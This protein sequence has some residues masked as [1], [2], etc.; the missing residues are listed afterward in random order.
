MKYTQLTEQDRRSMLE[1]LG[2]SVVGE[3]FAPISSAHRLDQPL[4]IPPGRS[5]PEVLADLT[6]LAGAN[7]ACDELVCFLG[8]GAYDHFI[9]TLVD[10]LAMKGEFLTAYTPYQAEASQGSLQAFYEFQTMVCQLLGMDV[11]NASLYEQASAVAEAVLMVTQASR[12]RRVLVCGA[13]HPDTSAVLATY[14]R[15]ADFQC[16]ALPLTDGVTDLDALTQAVDEQTAAVVVQ[17][18]NFFGCLEPADRIAQI[19]HQ[20]GAVVIGCTDP[21]ACGLIKRPGDWGADIAVAE[22]QAL[23]IPLSYGGPYVGLMACGEK[24]LRKMPG[25]VV[26]RGRD[27]KGSQSFCLALQTREQH[28]RRE[29][30]TSNICTNQGLMAL[31]VAVYLSAMG[32]Q[33][34]ATVAGHCLDKAHYA[35]GLIAG[36]DGYEL[37]F[38]QPF[39][40]EFTVKTQRN[41]SG[42]LSHCR[43]RGILAGVPLGRWFEPLADCFTV[44]VTEK[45]SKAQIDQLIEALKTA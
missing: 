5:E 40:K 19:A 43:D 41:V 9:P 4:N 45:R 32:K 8:S 10:H 18:P 6:E 20:A 30:A 15:P 42:V 17:T 16:I 25:R 36:L 12:K 2:V 14:A 35:A 21:L 39:F 11:A 13:V 1:T 3:L 44:A 37:R 34:M 27:A 33:G 7:N 29:R 26:G 38:D 23:G 24:W 28:I 31:R 22:G